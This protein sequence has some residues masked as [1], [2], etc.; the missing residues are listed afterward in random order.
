M[1]EPVERVDELD[2]VVGVVDRA[3]AVRRGW[4]HRVAATVCRDADGRVL[5]H[6]RPDNAARF[7][8]RYDWLVGG[9]VEVGE[10]YARAAVRELG[11]ELGV[12][13]MVRFAFKYLCHGAIGPYWMAV[14]EAVTVGE[15]AP[16]PAEI[17][18]YG[19]LPEAEFRRVLWQWPFVP[20]SRTAFTKYTELP[21]SPVA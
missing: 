15:F 8:G 5:V 14:H 2:R 13:A 7:P 17:A 11:E 10:S 3:E 6:R 19:W 21:G 4:P 1:S 20:D 9:A 16:D 12:R 18:W